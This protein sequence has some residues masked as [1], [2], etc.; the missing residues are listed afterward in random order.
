MLGRYFSCVFLALALTLLSPEFSH[1]QTAPTVA[2]DGC[3]EQLFT[4]MSDAANRG[5]EQSDDIIYALHRPPS[6]MQQFDCATTN[7]NV[8][9][10]SFANRL[11][12]AITSAINN[13]LSLFLSILDPFGVITALLNSLSF[14]LSG[15]GPFN[16][17][18]DLIQVDL[19]L[20]AVL[21]ALMCPEMWTDGLA[22][23]LRKVSFGI[24]NGRAVAN[25]GPLGTF[26]VDCSGN[27]RFNGNLISS[28][29]FGL[30]ISVL[31]CKIL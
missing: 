15:A 6:S 23:A 27:M 22:S 8:W 17:L 12:N 3:D 29:S 16:S 31:G 9:R 5:I 11:K 18:M 1:A 28:L 7:A 13:I 4:E 24:G 30:S 2:A 20:P 10:V 19:K 14:T 25:F 21:S 26:S